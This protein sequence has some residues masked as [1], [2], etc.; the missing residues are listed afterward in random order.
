[1]WVIASLQFEASVNLFF[2]LID[3]LLLIFIFFYS[4]QGDEKNGLH[5]K[6]SHAVGG[7]LVSK[8]QLLEN[9]L[10]EA[11][12]ANKKYKVQLKRWV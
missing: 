1:M 10:D 7:D 3:R 11:L 8:I 12:E 9:E 6:N 2:F 4:F 5:D